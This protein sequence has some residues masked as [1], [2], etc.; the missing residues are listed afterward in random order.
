MSVQVVK[1]GVVDTRAV[2]TGLSD[3]GLVEVTAGVAEGEL[4]VSKAGTFLRSGDR[5]KPR[6]VAGDGTKIGAGVKG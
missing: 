3:A 2:E 6:V 5:V 4:V 1:D